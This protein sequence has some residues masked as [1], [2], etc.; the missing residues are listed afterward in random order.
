MP[1]KVLALAPFKPGGKNIEAHE[2]IRIGKENFDQVLSDFGVSLY[3]SLPKDLCPSGGLTLSFQK[4]K[5][6][7][8]DRLIEHVPFLKNILEARNFVKEAKFMGLHEEE[9]YHHLNAW[10]DLPI[11]MKW[12]PHKTE[13]DSATPIEDILKMVA[14]P[15]ERSAPSVGI[16]P[17][18][19]QLD[20]LLQQIL[21]HI[22]QDES[23]R[24]L[25]SLWRGLRFLVEQGQIDGAITLEI[26]PVSYDT[27]EETLNHLMVHL[28]EDLPSLTLLDLPLDN[29]I[30][31]KKLPSFRRRFWFPRLAGSPL[32]FFILIRGRTSRSLPSYPI[33][34]MNLYLLSGVILKR[35]LQPGGSLSPAI[36]SSSAIPMALTIYRVQSILKNRRTFG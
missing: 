28:V 16:Q 3:L 22:F 13:R 18:S 32:T 14:M 8:P 21:K 33:I 1:F 26:V 11:E 6:F 27:L 29:S 31:L 35:P 9:I 4:I 12:E 36:D 24:N 2:P 23:F 25:E 17:F 5:D 34:L 20:S 19:T 15:E 7:H 10:P 30:S